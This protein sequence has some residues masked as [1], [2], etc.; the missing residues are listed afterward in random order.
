MLSQNSAF[1]AVVLAFAAGC[2]SSNGTGVVPV[3]GATGTA[4][5][6]S[7][8]SGGSANG[9]AGTGALGGAS[10]STG[11]TTANAGSGGSPSASGSGGSGGGAADPN[12]CSPACATGKACVMGTCMTAPTTLVTITGCSTVRLAVKSDTLYYTDTKAGAVRKIPTAGGTPSDVV[13]GQP[14][15]YALLV[16]AT[17]VYFGNL[18]DNTLKLV[19]TGGGTAKT[20]TTGTQGATRGLALNNN[21]L[22]YADG[23]NL[24]SIKPA[25]SSTPTVLG[26]GD[27]GGKGLPAEICVDDTT[28]YYTDSNAFGVERH[29]QVGTGDSIAMAGSQGD[30][31]MTAIAVQAGT[32]YWANGVTIAA[33]PITADKQSSYM[34]ATTTQEGGNYTGFALNATDF[35]LGENVMNADGS[36]TGYV[37]TAKFGGDGTATLLAANE[38][39]PQSF[40]LDSKGVYYVTI[41]GNTDESKQVCRIQKLPLN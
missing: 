36:F 2:S 8:S 40:V 16:D 31:V 33:K 9:T 13:T 30:I 32:V 39:S 4:G 23:H 19:P 37:E 3:T 7:M 24:N 29:P 35:Y 10:A 1:F 34:S 14:Q 12:T 27:D 5:T 41:D 22:F 38:P 28:V 17:N 6:T 26:Q 18:M 21:L 11:G 15:P 20:I 25:E